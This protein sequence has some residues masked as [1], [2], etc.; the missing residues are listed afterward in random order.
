MTDEDYIDIAIEI[1]KTACFP[2]GAIVVKDKKIIGRSDDITL[3]NKSMFP[4]AELHAIESA[5][6][7]KNLYGELAGSTIYTSCEPCTMCIGAILYEGINK[8]VYA[9][10][11]EDSDKYYNPEILIDSDKLFEYGYNKIEV[12]KGLHRE[13]AIQVFKNHIEKVKNRILITGSVLSSDTDLIN[14][15]KKLV[16][17]VSGDGFLVSSPID[18]MKFNG[19]DCE[20][21]QRALDLLKD[22]KYIIAELSVVSTGQGMELQEAVNLGIPILVIAKAGSKISSLVKGCRNVVDI[23]YYENIESIEMEVKKFIKK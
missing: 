2:Y 18:T 22:T 7:N 11:L 1:S 8:V 13:S 14:N 20:K 15:Y 19:T 6:K 17:I 3:I 9:A 4:H 12:V 23:I 10:T 5:S 16:N 21:Y